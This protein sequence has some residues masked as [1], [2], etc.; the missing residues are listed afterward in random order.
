L[1]TEPHENAVFLYSWTP[2]HKKNTN[3]FYIYKK[4]DFMTLIFESFQ[5]DFQL[6]ICPE[7]ETETFK[8]IKL[9]LSV[10]ISKNCQN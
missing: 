6:H 4:V 10:H 5:K 7:I 2:R 1:K 9:V 8:L 3:Y